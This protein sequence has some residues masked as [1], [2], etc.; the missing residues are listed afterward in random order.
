MTGGDK[1]RPLVTASKRE[2]DEDAMNDDDS[3]DPLSLKTYPA[4][5]FSISPTFNAWVKLTAADVHALTIHRGF[6]GPF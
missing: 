2:H 3:N 6:E 1:T 4:Y 5:C